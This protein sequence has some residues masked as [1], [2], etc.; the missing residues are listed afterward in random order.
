MTMLM[1]IYLAS[2]ASLFVLFTFITSCMQQDD[3]QNENGNRDIVLVEAF[4]QLSFTRPV[5]LQ[6]PGDGSDRLFIV[7]QRGVISVFDNDPAANS[8]TAFLD[9]SA[10]VNDQGNEEGLLGLAFHPQYAENGFFFVNYTAASPRRTV[11]SRFKVSA[12]DANRADP[13]SEEVL[14]EFNQPFSNHNGGQLA[15]GPDGMLYIA[16]G[17]GGS[18]GDP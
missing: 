6:H 10:K 16:V 1:K 18:G 15:F 2:F 4:P 13:G 7:E 9:I 14:L 17:D 12:A 3:R 11:I 8:K 5:D